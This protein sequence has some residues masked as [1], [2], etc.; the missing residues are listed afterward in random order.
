MCQMYVAYEQRPVKTGN[1]ITPRSPREGTSKSKMRRI[2]QKPV[3]NMR[4][5]IVW[6]YADF[7]SNGSNGQ[8]INAAEKIKKAIL[9]SE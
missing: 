9:R 8:V 6:T 7:S 4:K 1:L 5:P 2:M 3:A